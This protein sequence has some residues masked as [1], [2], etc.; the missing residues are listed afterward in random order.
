M[1]DHLLGTAHDSAVAVSIS[2]RAFTQD[3][4]YRGSSKVVAKALL[5][6]FVYQNWLYIITLIE[7]CC[8]DLVLRVYRKIILFSV[9]KLLNFELYFRCTSSE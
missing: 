8:R 9:V 2:F 5:V 4:G 3:G 1:N 6:I 7:H